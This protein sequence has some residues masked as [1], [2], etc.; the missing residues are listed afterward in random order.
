MN[1]VPEHFGAGVLFGLVLKQKFGAPLGSGIFVDGCGLSH[2]EVAIDK[3]RQVG[4]VKALI[5]L[6]AHPAVAVEIRS[7]SSFVDIFFK[8]NFGVGELVANLGSK[9]A[10]LPVSKGRSAVHLCEC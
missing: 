6:D 1:N 9:S 10:N 7:R 8:V 3:V 2:L 4:E 5:K